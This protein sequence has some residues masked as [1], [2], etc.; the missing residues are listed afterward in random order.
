MTSSKKDSSSL[1]PLEGL[2]DLLIDLQ[3]VNPTQK[4]SEES[5]TLTQE[6]VSE[7]NPSSADSVED[8]QNLP[9]DS[10][11]VVEPESESSVSLRLKEEQQEEPAKPSPLGEVNLN[12]AENADKETPPEL[13]LT[14]LIQSYQQKD[15]PKDWTN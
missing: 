13:K 10:S 12:Q 9:T 6:A 14:Q 7:G 11:P 8:Y 2:L 4:P 5:P 15:Q 3:V 1:S